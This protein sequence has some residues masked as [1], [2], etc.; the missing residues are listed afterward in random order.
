MTEEDVSDELHES[1]NEL[2]RRLLY[3][4]ELLDA[5]KRLVRSARLVERVIKRHFFINAEE[6]KGLRTLVQIRKRF[7]GRKMYGDAAYAVNIRNRVSHDSI[8][9]EPTEE[10]MTKA[11][12]VF[13]AIVQMHVD[14]LEKRMSSASS[15]SDADVEA[16]RVEDSPPNPQ[17]EPKTSRQPPSYATQ[18][19]GN[20]MPLLDALDSD[21]WLSASTIAEYRF[22][23]RAGVL[24]HEGSYVDAEEELPSLALLPWYELDAIQEELDRSL[25]RI[26]WML[27]GFVIGVVVL[28]LSP[29]VRLTGFPLM[30]VV[31]TG[32]WLN[33]AIRE[34]GRWKTL[35]ERRLEATIAVD[36]E[37]DPNSTRYQNVN[38][39]GLLRAGFEVRRPEAAM[40]D[41]R[42]KVSGK[43]R[44][45]L[46]KGSMS[47][48]VHRVQKAAGPILL[49]H[50]VRVMAHCHLIEATEGAF[51]PYAII[52][53]GDTY[54]G[55]TIPNLRE[56]RDKFYSALEHVRTMIQQ[57]DAG[58]W[59]PPEPATVSICSGCPHGFPRPA[60]K[61]IKT[62][63]YGEPLEPFLLANGKGRVFNCS[64]GDRFR[65]KP[66][67]ERNER[68][69]RLE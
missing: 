13:L 8:D 10:E 42:W 44:R 39:W 55:V 52:L 30:L 46:Q 11:A 9:G 65:W 21:P 56:N 26:F 5:E 66:K 1:I 2:Q 22:C 64:C 57:S 59:Q 35:A 61:E 53:F 18:V 25:R 49:Q 50:I 32:V 29:L 33:F 38:W 54:Q 43:P 3:V 63:R 60:V 7:L 16:D 17:S 31:C 69:V 14:E 51:C 34:Y 58:E 40:K 24:T 68:L 6:K 27:V 45:I 4:D 19:P 12:D 23:P 37:P 15:R 62:Y 20:P 28:V 47:V 67:H 48:P 41:E 36:C